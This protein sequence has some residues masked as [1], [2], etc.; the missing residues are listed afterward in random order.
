MGNRPKGTTL[1]RINNDGNYEPE[2]CRWATAREQ[3]RNTR[4]NKLI[5]FNGET[6]SLS[7]WNEK[8][9]FKKQVLDQ[10][11]AAGWSLERAFTTPMRG[12]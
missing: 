12:R 11:L 10:R 3:A 9:G 2:N 8:L 5:T 6:K 1:D 4:R 7:E